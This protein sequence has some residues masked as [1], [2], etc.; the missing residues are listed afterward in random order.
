MPAQLTEVLAAIGALTVLTFLSLEE[1]GEL[2][3]AR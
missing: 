2:G 1:F 3:M